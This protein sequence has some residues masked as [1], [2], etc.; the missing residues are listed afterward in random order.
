[1]DG[2]VA[3]GLIAGFSVLVICLNYVGLLLAHLRERRDKK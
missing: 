2:L 1:M 3:V